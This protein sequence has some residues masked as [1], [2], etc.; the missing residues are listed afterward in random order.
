MNRRDLIKNLNRL[1]G[2]SNG[3]EMNT[4]STST[5]NQPESETWCKSQDTERLTKLLQNKS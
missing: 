1:D 3:T 4:T 5:T 2:I